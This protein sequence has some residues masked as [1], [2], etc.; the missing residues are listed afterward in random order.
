VFAV[1]PAI[2]L[3]YA[4]EPAPL[5][6]QMFEVVGLA[7]ALQQTPLTV[8]DAPPSDVTLPPPLAVF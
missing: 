6:V 4:P 3:E 2:E 5:P 8:T 7:E 1:S